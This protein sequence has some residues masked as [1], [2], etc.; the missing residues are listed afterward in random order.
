[1]IQTKNTEL[2]TYDNHSIDDNIVLQLQ[3][4]IMIL[5][6]FSMGLDIMV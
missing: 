5:E 4:S 3:V 2:H 6:F 1:M